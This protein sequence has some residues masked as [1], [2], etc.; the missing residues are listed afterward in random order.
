MSQTISLDASVRTENP[1]TI[2]QKGSV[3]AVLYGHGIK[4]ELVQVDSRALEKVLRE[5]GQTSLV[6]LIIGDHK[7]NVLIRDIQLHPLKSNVT[8]ADFYQV[9]MDEKVKADVPL[10]IVGESRAVKDLSG[11]L[12]HNID[13]LEIEALPA[14]LPH[15]IQLDISSLTGFDKVIH[16]GDIPLPSGVTVL[17]DAEEVVALVQ[18]PRSEE[19]LASLSEEAKEDVE[20]VEGVVKKEEPAEGEEGTEGEKK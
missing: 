3:P 16:V 12:V 13:S 19:E 18:P 10:E 5:A 4:N 7:H 11:V 6:N 8:H 17:D 14:D 15:V 9:R 1:N 2:R 20:S